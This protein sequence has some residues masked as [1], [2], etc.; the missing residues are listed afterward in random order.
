M[1]TKDH[2]YILLCKTGTS[3]NKQQFKD[4]SLSPVSNYFYETF[5]EQFSSHFYK[6]DDNHFEFSNS[7]IQYSGNRKFN[8]LRS[9]NYGEIVI[10]ENR[11]YFNIDFKGDAQRAFL[12]FSIFF[13]P[14]LVFIT[15]ASHFDLYLI[16]IALLFGIILSL[17][18]WYFAKYS[19]KVF[20]DFKKNNL[21]TWRG[22]G[23]ADL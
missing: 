7:L 12:T 19:I 22:Y 14:F 23:H 17:F 9:F 2:Q 20:L 15:I 16:A 3:I 21:E 4:L 5:R 10:S 8:K 6:I 11:S 13:I 1:K 18:R